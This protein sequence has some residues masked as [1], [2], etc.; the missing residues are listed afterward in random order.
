[1]PTT[2]SRRELV[3]A[4]TPRQAVPR[5]ST[6]C[7]RASPNPEFASQPGNYAHWLLAH[8]F[9]L[10]GAA[11][12]AGGDDGGSAPLAGSRLYIAHGSNA[13]LPVWAA[14]YAEL[15]DVGCVR[16]SEA[17]LA[18]AEGSGG[19]SG[20]GSITSRPW[21]GLGCHVE[22]NVSVPAYSFCRRRP[23]WDPSLVTRVARYLRT[24]LGMDGPPAAAAAANAEA[25]ASTT[26]RGGGRIVV[27]V[28]RSRDPFRATV[29][30]ERA[31]DPV[32]VS[33][34]LQ[35]GVL[36]AGTSMECTSFNMSTPLVAMAR[37][38]GAPDALALLSGHGAGQANVLFMQRGRA[39]AE[40]DAIKNMG[41]ARNFYQYLA[42]SVG[43]RATK[44]WLNASGTRFC[45]PRSNACGAG[46]MNMYRASVAILPAVLDDVLREVTAE[47]G[48]P[49]RDCG[50][51][52]DEEGPRMF[53]T[54]PRPAGWNR[55]T[56]P[57]WQEGN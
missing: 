47:G 11:L 37:A 32:Y 51:A 24:R 20:S 22:L 21:Q 40:F 46:N 30:L 54:V 57:L 3:L 53:H 1:M 41:K 35:R 34:A 12:A 4:C 26:A 16:S 31:C 27:L 38:V 43:V 6:Y 15:F 13:V 25:G 45:P 39:M 7:V 28:R 23:F 14:R 55:L 17:P 36:P 56:A 19:G 18:E 50:V 29:G 44:V 33:S 10:V 49:L 42:E 48:R 2:R 8:L 9:P 5:A 52:S